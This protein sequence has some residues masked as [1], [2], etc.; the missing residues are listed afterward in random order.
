MLPAPL[1]LPPPLAGDWLGL[2]IQAVR[3][4]CSPCSVPLLAPSTV[5]GPLPSLTPRL[6]G[7]F[8]CSRVQASHQASLR[9][10]ASSLGLS[11]WWRAGDS[12]D[13]KGK[14]CH[15]QSPPVKFRIH[16]GS[17]QARLK[18]AP[19]EWPLS[20]CHRPS[21]TSGTSHSPNHFSELISATQQPQEAAWILSPLLVR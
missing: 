16:T 14:P 11:T 19:Q 3:R 18:F 8:P 6:R 2:P 12:A 20:R 10:P 17:L 5:P 4:P 1:P 21:H 15:T 9:T 13:T 7:C